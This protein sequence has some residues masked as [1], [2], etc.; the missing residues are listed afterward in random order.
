MY[1]WEK[2]KFIGFISDIIPGEIVK[3]ELEEIDTC[4]SVA[5]YRLVYYTKYFRVEELRNNLLNKREKENEDDRKRGESNNGENKNS[6]HKE[7]DINERETIETEIND[8]LD[9]I[10]TTKKYDISKKMKIHLFIL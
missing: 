6:K 4:D 1:G 3:E 10:S 2:K 8:N 5:I 9:L 7:N